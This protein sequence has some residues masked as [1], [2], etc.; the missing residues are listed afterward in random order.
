MPGVTLRRE[1]GREV[2]LQSGLL[3]RTVLVSRAQTALYLA[4]GLIPLLLNSFFI[5]ISS[6]S[7]ATGVGPF[8]QEVSQDQCVL[9]TVSSPTSRATLLLQAGGAP[10]GRLAQN[11]VPSTFCSCSNHLCWPPL[12]HLAEGSLCHYG[13]HGG[14][15]MILSPKGV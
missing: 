13:D 5:T 7:F 8:V 10:C 15:G 2:Y 4:A 6:A 14:G 1:G 12:G 11:F 3:K 9:Y